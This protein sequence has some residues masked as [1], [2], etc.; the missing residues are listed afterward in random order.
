MLIIQGKKVP[1]RAYVSN[2]TLNTSDLGTNI[3]INVLVTFPV[4][5]ANIN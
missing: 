3:M 1:N 5:R 4:P 2:L